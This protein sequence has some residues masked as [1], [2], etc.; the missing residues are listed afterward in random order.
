M[1]HYRVRPAT[2]CDA[3][4]IRKLLARA[5]SAECSEEEWA[6]KFLRNP[7]GW[8]G[9]VAESEAGE[10]VGNFAGW[11]MRFFLDGVERTVFS[12]GDVATIP[13]ARG[14]GKGRNV[15]GDM[16]EAFYEAVRQQGVPFTFG[17]PHSRAHEISRRLGHTRDYFPIRHVRV[18][19]AAFPDP[20]RGFEAA[21][22]VTE[23]FDGLWERARRR[24]GPVRDRVRVNW[25]FHARPTRYYRMVQ[26]VSGNEDRA[27]AVLSVLG[28]EAIVADFLG[29]Q[30]DGSDLLPL[31]S[32]AAAEAGRLGARRLL[33]W[34]TPGGPGRG[35]IDGLPGESR[36]AG[37]W[38]VGRVF[39][40]Q[41][42]RLYLEQGHFA[43]SLHD[44]V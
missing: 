7:D 17:F 21:D 32:A 13:A 33:F 34:A 41:A 10:I 12:A 37:F 26:L 22:F 25:R 6:W 30:P 18:D 15:Y 28:E 3:P 14:L 38:F 44:V 19:C 35:V 31:F 11:P 9:V 40:E 5:Y 43:P 24:V 42:A 20:P 29:V 4:G 23:S 39:D 36:D 1:I 16:A 2:E 8:F 27:W